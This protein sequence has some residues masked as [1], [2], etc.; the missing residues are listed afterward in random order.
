MCLLIF[1][2]YCLL[3]P[4]API[5]PIGKLSANYSV[6]TYAFLQTHAGVF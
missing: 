2:H 3:A 1:L 4:I 5:I 6:T